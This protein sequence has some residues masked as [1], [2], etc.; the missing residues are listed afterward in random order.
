[1]HPEFADQGIERH[2]LGGVIRRHL[3]GFFRG[4]N[5]ELAGIENQAAVRPCRDR[6]PEFT[7]RI[8]AA[9]VDIDHAGVALGA[10]A[11][12]AAGILAA[13]IDAQRDAVDKVGIVGI[14]QPL[15]IVQR[16]E[17]VGIED[18]IAG[19]K[20]DLAEAIPRAA[21]PERFSG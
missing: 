20:A 19:A 9:A 17:L 21:I 6:L 14:D 15:Q 8:A 7:D 5:V 3:D 2:H 12:E 18:G 1:M 16:V 11:D 13:E 4:E 10:V